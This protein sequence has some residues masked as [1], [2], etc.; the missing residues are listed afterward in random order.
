MLIGNAIDYKNLIRET[1]AMFC[2]FSFVD[3]KK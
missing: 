3:I 2:K 1:H